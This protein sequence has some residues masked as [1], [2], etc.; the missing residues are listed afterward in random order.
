MS[1]CRSCGAEIRWIKMRSGKNMPVDAAKRTIKKD[2]GHE[3]LV[4]EDGEL[5]RGTFAS[6]EEGANGVGYISHF[7]TCPNANQHRRRS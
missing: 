7:S 2:G 3:V 6:L 4:T 5:I 1:Y